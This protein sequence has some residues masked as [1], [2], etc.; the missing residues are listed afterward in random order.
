VTLNRWRLWF[1]LG[2]SL[3][4]VGLLNG[5]SLFRDGD[6]AWVLFAVIGICGVTVILVSAIR[7]R[8]TE[9]QEAAARAAAGPDPRRWRVTETGDEE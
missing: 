5:F 8:P 7:R 6:S 4:M 9:R 3:W 1:T 2:M